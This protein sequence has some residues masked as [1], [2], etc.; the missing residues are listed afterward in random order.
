MLT[1]LLACASPVDSTTPAPVDSA[2]D[3]AADTGPAPTG[4][5]VD[6]PV[7]VALVDGDLVSVDDAVD[8]SGDADFYAVDL[9]AGDDLLVIVDAGGEGEPD[10]VVQLYSPDG[11]LVSAD[12]DLPYRIHGTDSGQWLR[13]DRD[14]TW[15]VQVLDYTDWTGGS[16]DPDA[17]WNYS[18]ELGLNAPYTDPTEDAG[19]NTRETAEAQGVYPWASDPWSTAF[20]DDTGYPFLVGD[21]DEGDE[22]W[23]PLELDAEGVIEV[24]TLADTNSAAAPHL[25]LYADDG[26]LLASTDEPNLAPRWL[27]F[28]YDP[29]LR[30]AFSEATTAWLRVTDGATGGGL[31]HW[32]G[33]V[34]YPWAI[35]PGWLLHH[36][37]TGDGTQLELAEDAP[38]QESTVGDVILLTGSF[39]GEPFQAW[40]I[41]G[42]GAAGRYLS[43]N[44]A[45]AAD[46]SALDASLTILDSTG[47]VLASAERNPDTALSDDPTILNLSVTTDGPFYLVIDDENGATGPSAFYNAAVYVTDD[48]TGA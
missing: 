47:A 25:E 44:L 9:V 46:G 35:T 24:S 13:A 29:G 8:V 20:G 15:V 34:G 45:T 41:A 19:N 7:P 48:R 27:A 1:F 4:D 18:L 38:M 30:Y 11:E 21:L 17:T 2:T 12:D 23:F 39:D 42:D 31:A 16:S 14:G 5:S 32:Y 36:T 6:D 3:S 40:R 10:S 28:G 37:V 22:D 43:V 26:T 33:L